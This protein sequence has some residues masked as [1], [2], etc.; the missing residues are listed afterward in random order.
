VKLRFLI[1]A[2]VEGSMNIVNTKWQSLFFF[3]SLLVFSNLYTN[4]VKNRNFSRH[5][6]IHAGLEVYFKKVENKVEHS[7][8]MPQIDFIY[9]INLDE[10]PEKYASCIEKLIPYGIF[11]F[12]FSAVNGWQLPMS[13][14]NDVGFKFDYSLVEGLK[15]TNYDLGEGKPHHE[16]MHVTGR[17]YFSHGM[18]RGAIGIVLS[19]LSVLDALDSGYETIWVMEDDIEVIQNP[20]LLPSLINKLDALLGKDGWDILFT[21]RDTKDRQ[22]NYIICTSYAQKPNF[23]PANPI[24]FAEI[25][26]ISSDF[27]KIGARYGA[28]SMIVRRSGMKKMLNFIKKHKVFLPYDMEY[29]LPDDIRLYT[30]RDDVVSTQIRAL[31]DNGA[32]RYKEKG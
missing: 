21:D 15:G 23:V 4:G 19:H 26:D 31:S 3:F 14:L 13:T 17:N 32:P 22:G 30:L 2:I 11:P 6:C 1:I 12:R 28:Y 18:N 8:T 20:H 9:M 27:R 24:K 29:T 10:R 7:H 25:Q 5:L 16:V